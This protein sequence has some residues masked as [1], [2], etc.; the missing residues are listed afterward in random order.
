MSDETTKS[1]YED[2]IDAKICNGCSSSECTCESPITKPDESEV[3][4][5]RD[6][7][8]LTPLNPKTL[9]I[10]ENKRRDEL[11]KKYLG[12]DLVHIL[13]KHI[14]ANRESLPV[15]PNESEL[16]PIIKYFRDSAES[17]RQTFTKATPVGGTNATLFDKWADRIEAVRN[18]RTDSSLRT[19]LETTKCPKCGSV[20]IGIM[21]SE[22]H[23]KAWTCYDSRCQYAWKE[24]STV[25]KGLI[26]LSTSV[27]QQT[28]MFEREVNQ[29]LHERIA[30]LEA[31]R[32]ET[33]NML[34]ATRDRDIEEGVRKYKRQFEK[35]RDA[36]A[37][38]EAE[39]ERLRA[40]LIKI[41]QP[42]EDGPGM[43]IARQLDDRL[44]T[45]REALK[46]ESDT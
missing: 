41:S 17:H 5:I 4:E 18:A 11:R 40:A 9:S 19:E 1:S 38:L 33:V 35:Q 2:M 39:N 6:L 26:G 43:F 34:T 24:G 25:D 37:E 31:E 20:D 13:L 3:E 7:W 28:V 42:Y 27:L 14:D 30:E 23:N 36:V 16:E 29:Q 15:A 45:A 12:L 44:D 21:N 10:E 46:E 32:D 22:P 8:R